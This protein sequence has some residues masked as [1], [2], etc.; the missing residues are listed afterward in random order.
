MLQ[1]FKAVGA[2]A[3]TLT[4]EDYMGSLPEMLGILHSDGSGAMVKRSATYEEESDKD[5]EDLNMVLAK[6]TDS[7]T[8]RR[9]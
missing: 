9:K 8:D 3:F 4:R 5:N 1:R 7:A 6:F 2:K